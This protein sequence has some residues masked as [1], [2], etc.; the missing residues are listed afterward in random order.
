MHPIV[1][2]MPHFQPFD[3]CRVIGYN[4]LVI[5]KEVNCNTCQVDDK[6]QWS[7]SVM[8]LD[9]KAKNTKCAWYEPH[10]LEYVKNISHPFGSSAY[11]F[12]LERRPK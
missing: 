2:K 9:P 10:E 12:E 1:V 4:E 11:K 3:V 7:Y 5:I 8:L 6:W